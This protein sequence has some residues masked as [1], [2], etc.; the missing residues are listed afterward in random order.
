M[1]RT[2]LGKFNDA[3]S[4]HERPADVE[5]CTGSFETE[6]WLASAKVF[7]LFQHDRLSIR[8][9]VSVS[10]FEE[11]QEA[12]PTAQPQSLDRKR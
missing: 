4:I 6:R 1:K 7:G 9:G 12:K 2:D 5:D 10:Y 8:P 3:V 11:T